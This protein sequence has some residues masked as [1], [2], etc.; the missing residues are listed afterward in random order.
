MPLRPATR[1]P[2]L[3]HDAH[4]AL[5]VRHVAQPPVGLPS[6][7]R[8]HLALRLQAHPQLHVRLCLLLEHREQRVQLVRARRLQPGV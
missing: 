2:R 6:H 1:R 7:A 8:A 4:R 3:R 5:H